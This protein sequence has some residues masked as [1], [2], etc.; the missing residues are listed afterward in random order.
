V[1][2]NAGAT[3]E[4][5]SNDTLT[6]SSA[7][8]TNDGTVQVA[9]DLMGS[10]S[11][12]NA[13]AIVVTS[14][15][16]LPADG[17]GDSPGDL[18]VT[19]NIF[20]LTFT[21]ASGVSGAPPSPQW[22]YAATVKA[23]GGTL[24]KLRV[25]S[26]DTGAWDSGHNPVI[27]TTAL[28]PFSSTVA[29]VPTVALTESYGKPPKLSYKLSSAKSKT[30]FG[31]YGAPVKITFD[32]SPAK[33]AT[34][35]CPKPVVI[36][37]SGLH[38]AFTQPIPA[39]DDANSSIKV[40]EIKLDTSRP[41][42]SVTGVKSGATYHEAPKVKCAA[43]DRIS[44]VASC[45]LSTKKVKVVGGYREKVTAKATSKAGL[46]SQTTVVFTVKHG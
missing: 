9:G 33:G 19:G 1:T 6:L 34:I 37:N 2:V 11:L 46:T 16:E 31:W 35:S 24:P 7:T 21:L 3:L 25:P 15:G 29:G 14:T 38:P 22:V 27:G 36:S 18:T 17:L 42:L 43:S 41:K 4:V 12:A 10:G 44:G 30:A 40:S 39:S 13:G 28:K 23:D 45:K 20:K 8:N 26:G 32:C 5:P